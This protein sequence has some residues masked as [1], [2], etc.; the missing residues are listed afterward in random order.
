[1]ICNMLETEKIEKI[2]EFRI[3]FAGQKT[4]QA[5]QAQR[6]NGVKSS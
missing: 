2:N 4:W 6:V 1:M 5:G 3:F